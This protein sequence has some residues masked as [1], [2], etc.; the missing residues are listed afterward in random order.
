M[1]GPA[2]VSPLEVR[3]NANSWPFR[4][5]IPESGDAEGTRTS[6]PGRESGLPLGVPPEGHGPRSVVLLGV[7]NLVDGAGWAQALLSRIFVTGDPVAEDTVDPQNTFRDRVGH[8]RE[9]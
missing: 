8:R 5:P 7:Q 3:Q 4:P 2:C 1:K 9:G 6:N